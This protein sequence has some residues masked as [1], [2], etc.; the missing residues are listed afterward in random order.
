MLFRDLTFGILD[1]EKSVLINNVCPMLTLDC[2]PL[3]SFVFNLTWDGIS[4]RGL[5]CI[6]NS[7]PSGRFPGCRVPHPASYFQRVCITCTRCYLAASHRSRFYSAA[8]FC[9]YARRDV[10]PLG[11]FTLN[12]SGCP[13]ISSYTERL[14][15]VI[16]QLVPS[17]S[18]IPD[19]F[20]LG[21]LPH[22]W[23]LKESIELN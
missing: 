13:T 22:M 20:D 1:I 7:C 4:Q 18:K 14:Y 11:K 8:F 2:A 9:R 16:Q 21:I 15:K 10:L 12:L 6:S 23:S 19:L 3:S 17:V 5:P